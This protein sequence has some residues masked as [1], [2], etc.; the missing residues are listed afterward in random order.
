[1]RDDRPLPFSARELAELFDASTD[2][3]CVTHILVAAIARL[4]HEI[5]QLQQLQKSRARRKAR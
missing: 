2:A 3:V 4:T 5:L 1:M